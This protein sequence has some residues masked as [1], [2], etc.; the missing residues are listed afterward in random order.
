[1]TQMMLYPE[2]KYKYVRPGSLPQFHFT[3]KC[4]LEIKAWKCG[5]KMRNQSTTLTNIIASS[6]WRAAI[7]SILN[8]TTTIDHL[9]ELLGESLA[10]TVNLNF[11]Q[12]AIRNALI[13]FWSKCNLSLLKCILFH[14]L[15]GT[16]KASDKGW[17]WYTSNYIS[18]WETTN[19]LF[20]IVNR[21]STMLLGNISYFRL[22]I[23]FA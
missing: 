23:N 20:Y 12:R 7:A 4:Y 10:G 6:G 22:H 21:I 5:I 17:V 15:S 13:F 8:H 18:K 1:M 16:G 14:L 9:Y 3:T 11:Q 2:M 19:M